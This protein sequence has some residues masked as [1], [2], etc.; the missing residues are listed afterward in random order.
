MQKKVLLAQKN[1]LFLYEK[2]WLR[3]T[4]RTERELP[5]STQYKIMIIQ[6]HLLAVSIPSTLGLVTLS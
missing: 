1:S 3:S 4:K 6:P 5:M 2:A